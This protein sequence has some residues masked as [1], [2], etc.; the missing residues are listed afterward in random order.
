MGVWVPLAFSPDYRPSN[1]AMLVSVVHWCV[2]CVLCNC[3]EISWWNLSLYKMIH[4]LKDIEKLKENN[5]D[6]ESE[7]ILS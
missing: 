4:A 7:L 5:E 1:D 3:G 2:R 6:N